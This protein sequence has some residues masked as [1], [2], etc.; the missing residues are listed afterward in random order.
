MAVKTEKKVVMKIGEEAEMKCPTC[1]VLFKRKVT[2][3][4]NGEPYTGPANCDNCQTR[5]LANKRLVALDKK[6]KNIRNMKLRLS[7]AQKTKAIGFISREAARTIDVLKGTASK[8][9]PV[10]DIGD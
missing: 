8:D 2:L 10:F 3:G 9:Q 5:Q 4:T 6:F 1:G 7:P